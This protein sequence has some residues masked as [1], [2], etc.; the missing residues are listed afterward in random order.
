MSNQVKNIWFDMTVSSRGQIFIP[1]AVQR[2]LD[3]GTGDKVRFR[4]GEKGKIVFSK[5]KRR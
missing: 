1:K 2:Y 3:I 4:V 5:S